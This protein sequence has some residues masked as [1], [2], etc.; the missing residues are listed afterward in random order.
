MEP[1]TECLV[2]SANNCNGGVLEVRNDCAEPLVL[3]DVAIAPGDRANLDIVADNG[4]LELLEVNSNFSEYVPEADEAVEILGALG[5][6][7]VSVFLNKTKQLC[8]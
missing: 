1:E 8:E 7:K 5:S 6:Q 2:I 3:G 4:E